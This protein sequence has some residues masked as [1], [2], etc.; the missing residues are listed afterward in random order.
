MQLKKMTFVRRPQLPLLL[1]FISS[2]YLSS[3]LAMPSPACG[4]DFFN[5]IKLQQQ[6]DRDRHIQ[7]MKTHGNS[8]ENMSEA[9]PLAGVDQLFSTLSEIAVLYQEPGMPSPCYRWNCTTPD[10]PWECRWCLPYAIIPGM[11]KSGTSELFTLLELHPQVRGSRD[12]EINIFSLFQFTSL[13]DFEMKVSAYLSFPNQSDWWVDPTSVWIDGSAVCAYY[14]SCMDA[15][16]K[17]SPAT[18]SIVMVRDP[19]QRLASFLCMIHQDYLKQHP[20][21]LDRSSP[22]FIS[23]LSNMSAITTDNFTGD[24]DS[25]RTIFYILEMRTRWKDVLV[26]DNYNLSHSPNTTLQQI[27]LFLG[28]KPYDSYGPTS[29]VNSFGRWSGSEVTQLSGPRRPFIYQ[30][31][32]QTTQALHN[33]FHDYLCVYHFIQGTPLHIVTPAGMLV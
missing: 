10:Y 22:Q 26:L 6:Q 32:Q 29:G 11:P 14:T 20:H 18:K 12:K 7:M 2:Q 17:Y 24:Y 19:Y 3:S 25:V 9:N 4:Q 21:L 27:E 23:W 8:M 5:N 16:T 31:D 30:Y 13:A 1:L 28:I 33:L 15:L